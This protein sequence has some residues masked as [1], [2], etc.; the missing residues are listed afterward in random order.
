MTRFRAGRREIGDG[1]PCFIIA[2]AGSN[3]NGRLSMAMKLIDVAARAGADAVKF[4]T[5]RA[6]RLYS[7]RAGK[8]DYLKV[9]KSIVDIIRGMEMPYDWIPKLAARCRAKG[10]AFIS[11]PFDEESADRLAPHLDVFKIASYELNHEPLLRHVARFRKPMIVSTGA[12]KPE[13]VD[14]SVSLLRR[15]RVPGIAVLQCTARYPALV[16]SLNVRVLESYRRRYR[17][18]A[19]LSDHS[20]DP[21]TGPLTAAALGADL[22]EK[23]YTLDNDLP[24]PDHRFAVEPDE[25]AELVRRVREVE[26]ARGDGVKRVHPTEIELRKF[27]RRSLFAVADIAPGERFTR[28]NVAVLRN[29]KMPPGLPPADLERVLGHVCARRLSAGR[30]ID[31][32]SLRR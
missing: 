2:E 6:S 27:A 28:A 3:H 12:A 30:P 9:D 10:L 20:R 29:G 14:R 18:P 24:G 13:E 16:E 7:P 19:G 8:S 4:Q 26:R 15:L 25:L 23:H 1:R 32:R 11:T 17:C 22:L 31:S 21:L 5:F